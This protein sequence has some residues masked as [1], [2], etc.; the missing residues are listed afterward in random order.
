LGWRRAPTTWLGPV[1]T[2]SADKP[3]NLGRDVAIYQ[4]GTWAVRRPDALVELTLAAAAPAAARS[5]TKKAAE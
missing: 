1:R 4:F 2:L 3:A 5:T